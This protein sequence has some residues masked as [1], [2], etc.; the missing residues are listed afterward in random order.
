MAAAEFLCPNRYQETRIRASRRKRGS[1]GACPL[2]KKQRLGGSQKSLPA[3]GSYSQ[4]G[5]RYPAEARHVPLPKA[6]INLEDR[7]GPAP[8]RKNKGLAAARKASLP[9]AATPNKGNGT[10]R[11][12]K[13]LA[14]R[15]WLILRRQPKPPPTEGGH[16]CIMPASKPQTTGPSYVDRR[17]RRKPHPP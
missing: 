14:H 15:R 12:P 6:A 4:Q 17:T 10:R 2:Q 13:K 11:Q 7:K 5:H 9:K 1:E 16:R 3:E 8:C